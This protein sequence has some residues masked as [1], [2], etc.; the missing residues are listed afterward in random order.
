LTQRKLTKPPLA[1]FV[2]SKDY[3]TSST[4]MQGTTSFLLK[5]KGLE[6]IEDKKDERPVEDADKKKLDG[7]AVSENKV[8]YTPPPI[9]LQYPY[10]LPCP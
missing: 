5:D 4:D 9:P 1:N 2:N 6:K 7:S 10:T 8:I 3:L